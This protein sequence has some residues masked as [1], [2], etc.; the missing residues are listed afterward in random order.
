MSNYI[1]AAISRARTTLSVFV[2]IM[3]T[4]FVSYLSI[5]VELNPDVEVPIIISTIIHDGISPE[6][7]E[8]L[9]AKP[10][11]LELKTLDGITSISSFSS[12][13][14]ATIITEFD[15]DFDSQ[16]ALAEVREA[17]N[18]AKARFPQNTEE[19]LFQEVSAASVPVVT[20]AIG[21]E[22]VDER[23]LLRIAE[24]LQREIEIL[25]SVLEA[26]MVGNR[27]ELLEAVVDP[28][29]LETYGIPSSAI[30]Q[31]VTSNNRLIPA[32][33][34]DTGQ[35]SFSVKVPG[36]IENAN[37]LFDLPIASTSLG[38][39]TVSDIADVRRTFK[40]ATR[41]SYANGS[42]SISLNVKKRKGSNLVETMEQVDAVVQEIRPNLPPAVTL[43]YINNTAPLVIEQNLGLQGNMAT[44][45]VLVLIVV[46]AAVGVRSGLIVTLAVPF[47]FFFAFIIISLLG[48]TYNFMVI[49]GLLLGLGM[50]ID[51]AIVMVEYAD[52]KMAEG[53]D[54]HAAYR[55]AVNRMFWPI[56]A[57][58]A[59]TL[60]AFLPIMFWPGVAGQFMSYLPITVFAVLIG[61]L[62]YALLFA[63]TIGA[64]IGRSTDAAKAHQQKLISEG[65]IEPTGITG[66]YARVLTFAVRIPITVFFMSI[67][68]LVSIVWAYGEWG[69]GVE[70]FTA[71]EPSQTQV[72]VFARGNFSA[73]ET[74]DIMLDVERRIR[75]VGHFK[76]IV[77]QSGAGQQLGGDQQTA[78]DI[79]GSIFIEMTDRRIREVDG[80]EVEDMYRQAIANIPGARAEVASIEQGPPTGKEIQ[81]ELAG[82]DLDALFAEASRIRQHMETEMNN[83]LIDID[84]T[85]P[86]PGIEW[87]IV[88]DRAQAAMLGASM[89]EIGS[90]IQLM[91]NGIFVGDYRPNDSEEE[92]DIRV[93]YP[94]EFRGLAQMDNI[95]ISTANGPV[96][97]SS[98]VTRIA[99]PKVS[100]IQR[101]DGSRV[102]Y[103]RA[104]P[105][106]GIIADN[107]LREL[108]V[109]MEENPTR[110]GVFYQFRGANEEQAESAAFLGQA[111]SLA[112]ALMA[113]LLVTQFNSYYQA[114][115][116]LSS[117]LLST[118][119]VLLGLLTTGQTFS[120]ILTGI[121]IVALAGIIV[122]NNIVLIDTFNVLKSENPD[123][124][125]EKLVV[126]TG[127]QRLRPVFLTTFTTGFGLLPLAAHVSIDL[128][129]AEIEVGGPITSQWVSLASAIVF[130]LSFGTI[131]TLV[132]TPAMLALPDRLR[133]LLGNIPKLI[134]RAQPDLNTQNR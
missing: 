122:N 108:A 41:Y 134:G 93:R 91:T 13:N 32:G 27:E 102:V 46:I 95:R 118:A 68:T 64:L 86:V 70:F 103:V 37:D 35:G 131:L 81:V 129:G 104:N 18:R 107:K 80:F 30:V 21:G 116:I 75:E 1:D 51:G 53:M 12:E 76:G 120:V 117:V 94:A 62:F 119:G 50:L 15:I 97:I 84:D 63:P 109:Y 73:S 6:D 88:V 43:S 130:G 7:A 61:S 66:L 90:A 69:K 38:V 133:E 105:A 128:I 100:S 11:E 26:T 123:W 58:T 59:T 126:T 5:P 125:I 17:V 34:V 20:I 72:Q 127:V 77:T 71:V 22:G 31:A 65:E 33:Q 101:V 28:A 36:L 124:T 83:E 49:F 55:D 111:F 106:P 89:A 57:S 24:N 110:P 4:G 2:A 121:G 99:K 8:R 132:V 113:I 23:T 112:M 16:F 60:A 96:P 82:D 48:F 54:A 10:A 114:I 92:V 78:P 14:A 52:R 79:I 45:M 42:A 85:A 29:I 115:L 3:L 47:S 19:P 44:A 40:D 56:M 9:L 39:L 87:E 74:R 67:V 25:P 98:F